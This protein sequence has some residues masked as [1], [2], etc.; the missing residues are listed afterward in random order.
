MA[1]ELPYFKFYVSEWSDGDIT[2]EDMEVQGLFINICSY[3][4]SNECNLTLKKAEKKFR[5]ADPN[6]WNTILDERLIKVDEHDYISISFLDEQQNERTEQSKLKSKGG[7]ASA[8][9]RRLKK[10]TEE[11]QKPNTSSTGNQHVLNS[12]STEVQVLREEERRRE[13][14]R[15]EENKNNANAFSFSKSFIELGVEKQILNDWLKV[16]RKKK[17][18]D[19]ETSFNSLKAQIEKSNKTANECIRVCVENDW[20]GFKS[21]WVVNKVE[22]TKKPWEV[23]VL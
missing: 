20:K 3:Y 9:A 19:S 12:C 1:K 16:R 11:E 21:E 14:K 5:N 23:N 17:A 15:K 4:W 13:E 8:E 10:L 22:S 6:L 18:T 2:L 7:K